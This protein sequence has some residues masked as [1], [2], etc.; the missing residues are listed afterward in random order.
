M[1]T[2]EPMT[3]ATMTTGSREGGHHGYLGAHEGYRWAVRPSTHGAE[4]WKWWAFHAISGH[5]D[6]G[7]VRG[8]WG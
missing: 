4:T 8:W 2:K 1:S 5:L 3:P 7:A 6:C